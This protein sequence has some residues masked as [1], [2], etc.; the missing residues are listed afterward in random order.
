MKTRYDVQI[1]QTET[2][3]RLGPRAVPL[4]VIEAARRLPA[5]DSAYVDAAGRVLTWKELLAGRPLM[6][7]QRQAKG[8]A[9]G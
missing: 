3:V 6:E 4:A 9:D 8:R 7:D 2:D 1:G 5:G